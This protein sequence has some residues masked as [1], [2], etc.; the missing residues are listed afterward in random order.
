MVWFVTYRELFRDLRRS[1]RRARRWLVL[2]PIAIVVVVSNPSGYGPAAA[3]PSSCDRPVVLVG[4]VASDT[5]S[6]AGL[7]RD[8]DR[9]GMCA[10]V[11]DYG[12]TPLA[13]D[14]AR[15]G[16]P[17]LNGLTS[18]EDSGREL[19]GLL[20]SASPDRPLTVV[21]HGGGA[22]AVQYAL[23][24]GV[25]TGRVARLITLGPLWNGTGVAGLADIEQ[26]SRRLG[27]YDTVLRLERPI[28]DP[29]CAS[30]RQLV[31]G[32]D[33]LVAMRRAAFPTPGVSYVDIVSRTDGLAGDPR[34]STAPGSRVVV[35]QSID[36]RANV[37]HFRLPADT[38]VRSLV[39]DNTRG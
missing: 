28:V 3:R 32:S 33:F 38:L 5:V 22:L 16:G 25:P 29:I 9:A 30:C 27:T 11:L 37:D 6:L 23:T 1:R 36:P 10:T 19:A 17:R 39:V 26:I 34:T 18:L 4:E 13:T 7:R 15:A 20:R 21:A 35:L 14:L 24:H 31:T 12:R 2:L 8:L